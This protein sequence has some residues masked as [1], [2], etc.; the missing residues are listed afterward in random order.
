MRGG[1]D[2]K[3]G[4][5]G[6]TML[7]V[8]VEPRAKMRMTRGQL[9]EL[10]DSRSLRVEESWRAMMAVASSTGVVGRAATRPAAAR[11]LRNFMF[12]VGEIGG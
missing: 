9:D 7:P 5:V 4:F 6:R 2:G 3:G 10:P 8:S 11:M 1:E 12:A